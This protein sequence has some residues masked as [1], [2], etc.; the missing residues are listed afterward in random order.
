VELRVWRKGGRPTRLR[1]PRGD[2]RRG[3]PERRPLL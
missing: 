1:G 3:R 2:P